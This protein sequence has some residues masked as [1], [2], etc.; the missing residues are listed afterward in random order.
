MYI[1]INY[2]INVE[3]KLTDGRILNDDIPFFVQVYQSGRSALDCEF[4][5][6]KPKM[7]LMT[8]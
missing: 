8:E 2:L 1:S 5:Y 4:Q 3:F 6:P 7:F